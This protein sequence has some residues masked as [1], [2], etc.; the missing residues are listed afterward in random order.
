MKRTDYN[1]NEEQRG[2]VLH[3]DGPALVL[4]GAGSGKTRVI[5]YRLA[6]LLQEEKIPAFNLL[7]V[8]FTN[9]AAGAMKDRV[10]KLVGSGAV[11]EMFLG[12]FHALCL[13]FLKV[14]AEKLGYR[15]GFTIYDSDDQLALVKEVLWDLK[16]DEKETRPWSVHSF[17]SA[18]K[19]ELMTPEG[20]AEQAEGFFME[21]VA[22][23]YPKYQAK[24]RQNNAMDFDDLLFNAVRLLEEFPDILA[25][26]Q[27][28]FRYVMVDEYQDINS[29]QYRLVS[30]LVAPHKNLYVVGDPDQSIYGWRGA[31][32][33]NILRFEH[34]FPGSKV[35]KLEQ[36]YRSTLHHHPSRTSRH[37]QQRPAQR[38]GLMAVREMG[39]PVLYYQAEDDKQEA[40]F[41]ARTDPGAPRLPTGFQALRRLVPNQRPVACWKRHAVVTAFPMC[42]SGA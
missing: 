4:A 24:L 31:D 11:K 41:V 17:V 22:Q 15:P 27:E 13:R 12:T 21:K 1:L 33:R 40:D 2:A 36:N 10:S 38:E 32:I 18:A 35:F 37:P 7:G 29:A 16:M 30:H 26:Y 34:D 28:R 9:K 19:N 25:G 14:H 5:T 6:R 20:Y 3:T 23:V 8:T 39:E 42:S